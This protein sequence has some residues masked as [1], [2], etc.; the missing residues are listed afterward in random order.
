MTD[1]TTDD[2]APG[3]TPWKQLL[4]DWGRTGI[5]RRE[6]S[7]RHT[8]DDQLA[9]LRAELVA[10]AAE[11]FEPPTGPMGDFELIREIGRGGMGIVYEAHQVSVD[12]RVAL[13]LLPASDWM[14][15]RRIER[16]EHEARAAAALH[17]T[18]IV[19][20]FSSG[21]ELGTHFLAM[22]Y[23]DGHSLDQVDLAETATSPQ[24]HHLAVAEIG[25]QVAEALEHAHDQGVIHRDVKPANLLLDSQGT[26]WLSDFGLAKQQDRG[27][28]TAADAMVGTHL[29]MAPECF[30]GDAD[31]RSD[32]Y[33]LAATLHEM[34]TG[35]PLFAP[36]DSPWDRT[37]RPL[38]PSCP[39]LSRDLETI[40]AQSLD[41]DPDRRYQSAGEMA[42]DLA[43]FLADEPIRARRIGPV[44]RMARWCR[45]NPALAGMTS[46][47]TL[48]LLAL[49][50]G[51]VIVAADFRQ[52]A[53]TARALVQSRAAARH[54]VRTGHRREQDMRA[55]AKAL[56]RQSNRDAKR[57]EALTRFLVSDV[58]NEFRP[59][60]RRGKPL[61]AE[62]ILDHAASRV[63][64]TF[65]EQPATAA[66][67]QVALGE[68]YTALGLPQK[69]VHQWEQAVHIRTRELGK[70]HRD[71]LA[72]V[73]QLAT[74]VGHRG[75]YTQALALHQRAFAGLSADCQASDEIVLVA[76]HNLALTLLKL[77][78]FHEA[79]QHGEQVL[80]DRMKLHGPMHIRT[81]RTMNN[82]LLCHKG[83]GQIDE[84]MA[85]STRLLA[86]RKQSLGLQ[87]PDTL[88]TMH[89]HAQ[90]LAIQRQFAEAQELY[91]EILQR[92][93][94]LLGADHPR[95]LVTHHNLANM[96]LRQ[97]RAVEAERMNRQVLKRRIRTLGADHPQT[98]KTQA[99]L[100]RSLL[101]QKRYAEA[102][103][104][105]KATWTAQVARRGDA[106]ADT[107]WTLR[108]LARCQALARDQSLTRL[109]GTGARQSSGG[110]REFSEN[111]KTAS[112]SASQN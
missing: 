91:E 46:M 39:G 17:H 33:S 28:L 52:Q 85:L 110:N 22:Q 112:E 19:P 14:D 8:G 104:I 96:H 25:R 24:S 47:A 32:I 88:S 43:R 34:L 94:Q 18:N 100:G 80:A 54:A 63:A 79:R 62:A 83:L 76:Q 41:P 57:A 56:K 49:T 97:G 11:A 15:A 20:V 111:R 66:S 45:R 36:D 75:L 109:V 68:S 59:E 55:E 70:S 37:E 12:R 102:E 95:T 93:Q 7:S 74:A 90:L 87:H 13:K 60:R 69:A 99:N 82:L 101:K 86:I 44:G 50:V 48:L 38:R 67:I 105:L 2:P 61:V 98:L 42:A 27:S 3:L 31:A 5:L 78:R 35:Q 106:H 53:A 51:S 4:S 84:A 89:N 107:L 65:A 58:I 92:K 64:S 77:H 10:D 9:A 40:I 1:S 16:F 6:D 30:R 103:T 26:V 72:A 108:S 21:Y 81:M 23:I 71:T 29:Y 73:S